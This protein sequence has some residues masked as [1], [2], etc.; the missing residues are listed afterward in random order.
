MFGVVLFSTAPLFSVTQAQQTSQTRTLLEI[1]QLRQEISELRDMI[2][3][4]QYQIRKMQKAQSATGN[5]QAGA[6]GLPNQNYSGQQYPSGSSIPPGTS[7]GTSIEDPNSQYSGSVGNLPQ[8][9]DSYP[10]GA[11]VPNYSYGSESAGSQTIDSQRANTTNTQGQPNVVGGVQPYP[12]ASNSN[13]IDPNINP[14]VV[15]GVEERVITAPPTGSNTTGGYPPVEERTVGGVPVDRSAA[16][17]TTIGTATGSATGATDLPSQQYDAYS[18]QQSPQ[19]IPNRPLDRSAGG[20]IAVPPPSNTANTA[21]DDGGNTGAFGG[22]QASSQGISST[23]SETDYYN[24]GFGLMKQSK[25]EEAVS[26]F[27][28]QLETYPKGDSA[29]DAHYWIA[30]AM[31]VSRDLPVAKKH[32]KTLIQDYPQSRRVPDAMLK[33]AYI[34]QQQGNQIEARILFQEIVNFH[35]KSD[36][37]IAAKNRLAENN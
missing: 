10:S 23:I 15:N 11:A 13:G 31:Y 22:Q 35:P 7:S 17:G 32:L 14:N 20:V 19:A 30:E 28:K 21:R 3:R 24:Q 6:Q 18:Q 4:Q 27:E 2:E 26:I 37:A 33:T 29:D 25:F 5:N 1:Q 36:A 16:T 12:S 34:E 9:S 8:A